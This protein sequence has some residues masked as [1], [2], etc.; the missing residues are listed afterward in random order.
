[1]AE[2]TARV[3]FGFIELTPTQK[4]LFG[5]NVIAE[6]T[7]HTAEFPSPDIPIATLIAVNDDLKLKTQLAMSG[8]KERIQQR[9]VAEKE[10]NTQFRKQGQYVERI[11]SG[12]KLLIIQGGYLSIDTEVQPQPRPDQAVLSAWGNKAKGSIHAEIEP[13]AKVRGIVFTASTMPVTGQSMSIHNKQLRIVGDTGVQIEAI[14]GT[15][16]KVD[17]TGL[18]SGT[19]YYITAL[20]FNASGPGDISLT[21]DVIAP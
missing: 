19:R 2:K 8:D 4:G 21:V 9:D 16:R 5:D 7:D 13:L 12:S 20:G 6:L 14:L 3:S 18:V 15:K 17:F 11:A 1:M 10:W